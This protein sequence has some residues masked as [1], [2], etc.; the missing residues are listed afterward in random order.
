[1]KRLTLALTILV[2]STALFAINDKAGTSGF[3]FLKLNFSTKAAAMGNAYT[4]NG[5]GTDGVSFNSAAL[6]QVE[7][8]EISTGYMNY[9]EGI[10]IGSVALVKPIN[11]SFGMSVFGHFL[12]AE[13]DRT[14]IDGS[15]DYIGTNG[16]FGMSDLI[17]GAGVGMKFNESVDVGV[18]AKYIQQK[19]DD[20][21][22]TAVA[23]DISILHQTPNP[24]VKVGLAY[25]NVGKQLSYNTDEENEENL[26]TEFVGG[27]Y[28]HKERFSAVLDVSKPNDFDLMA[29]FGAE[30]GI[31]ELLSLR[32]GYKSNAGD[33][34]N[35]GDWELFSGLSFGAG[36]S[37]KKYMIDYAVSS[38]GDLGMVNQ[39]S[40]A[41]QF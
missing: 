9:I 15:G 34:R 27:I 40:L 25:K 22:S 3:T 10:H 12:S 23:F 29:R 36:F 18:T 4:G 38:Y 35:G 5:A 16:T 11:E 8:M 17:V 31:H 30:Y 13:E 19:L 39:I 33:W 41:Y 6:A 2:M 37:W 7:N 14:I 20:A 1:M 21:I 24:S 32:A 28:Y 26:P